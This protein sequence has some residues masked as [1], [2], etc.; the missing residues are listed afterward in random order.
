[1]ARLA[2]LGG[3]PLRP[4]VLFRRPDFQC[5]VAGVR[6]HTDDRFLTVNVGMSQKKIWRTDYVVSPCVFDLATR[7]FTFL[8]LSNTSHQHLVR[9]NDGWAVDEANDGPAS[10]T[11]HAGVHFRDQELRWAPWEELRSRSERFFD[12]SF[13]NPRLTRRQVPSP[14][15]RPQAGLTI[16]M[17]DIDLAVTRSQRLEQLLEQDFGATGRGL[18]EKVSSIADSMPQDLV[19]KLRLVAT[20]RNKVVHESGR[21]EDKS[22][23]LD[24]ADAAERELIKIRNRRGT[25]RR[26]MRRLAFFFVLAIVA[27]LVVKLLW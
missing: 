13:G 4:Q 11:S 24:A 16:T 10:V 3:D 7:T 1:V 26:G 14:Q 8:P 22:R 12:G 5:E 21:I 18:H 19:R 25:G 2:I 9:L 15:R 27:Y 6:W 17:S 23:F 20:V